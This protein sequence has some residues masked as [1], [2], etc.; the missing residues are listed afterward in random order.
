MSLPMPELERPTPGSYKGRHSPFYRG[1]WRGSAVTGIP[2]ASQL[3]LPLPACPLA[4]SPATGCLPVVLDRLAGRPTPISLALGPAPVADVAGR[5]VEHPVPARASITSS[6]S[7][8][9]PALI[10]TVTSAGAAT[11]PYVYPV[12]P[13]LLLDEAGEDWRSEGGLPPSTLPPQLGRVP[14]R[15]LASWPRASQTSHFLRV[16]GRPASAADVIPAGAPAPALAA[17]ITSAA[18]G[19]S[20]APP[21]SLVA[22]CHGF[23]GWATVD[24]RTSF[25]SGD[26]CRV[27]WRGGGRTAIRTTSWVHPY[28]HLIC[29]LSWGGHHLR[30]NQA[31]CLCPPHLLAACQWSWRP[32]LPSP[33]S[34]AAGGLPELPAGSIPTTVPAGLVAAPAPSGANTANN[35]A[36]SGLL[37]LA[38]CQWCRIDQLGD[39]L[40]QR[41]VLLSLTSWRGRTLPLSQLGRSLPKVKMLHR[42]LA[43]G[44]RPTV[45]RLTPASTPSP[46]V[47]STVA[48][49]IALAIPAGAAIACNNRKTDWL[50]AGGPGST[51]WAVDPRYG[52]EPPVTPTVAGDAAVP[53]PAGLFPSP[54]G[55]GYLRPRWLG[56]PLPLCH[57]LCHW[58]L[59][60]R[61]STR[62]AID[63]RDRWSPPGTAAAAGYSDLTTAAGPVAA[64]VAAG[65]T[66]AYIP[67]RR[68]AVLP[69]AYWLLAW[70]GVDVV[71]T[72]TTT[73]GA[74]PWCML[75]DRLVDRLVDLRVILEALTGGSFDV[76]IT[77]ENKNKEHLIK[78]VQ[79]E[80]EDYGVDEIT[81]MKGREDPDPDTDESNF[82]TKAH[83]VV[84]GEEQRHK[85]VCPEKQNNNPAR[86]QEGRRGGGGRVPS[87][88]GEF[89][90]RDLDDCLI[91]GPSRRRKRS[92]VRPGARSERKRGPRA[93]DEEEA[94]ASSPEDDDDDTLM[95]P[96][97]DK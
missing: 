64:P 57:L 15:L 59:A 95:G 19:P 13:S 23:T 62:W 34:G 37:P 35:M 24:P 93:K 87:E 38:A 77:N 65:V 48:G 29:P 79:E 86:C 78:V 91:G 68:L 49:M 82:I 2:A 30:A 51:S 80:E 25:P 47:T 92:K 20:A 73:G 63:S 9:R 16:A 26:S 27:L 88:R 81:Q 11:S 90:R 96:L 61:G 55:G 36:T 58:L 45:G 89:P 5:D 44:S 84:E 18:A 32:A 8:G 85:A 14:F 50:L 56:L 66:I 97:E 83:K 6:P 70:A 60:S 7:G 40:S 72:T 69:P 17:T 33:P 1:S 74:S 10:V 71:D 94:K 46:P 41:P 43:G 39:R 28:S 4:A 52:M 75:V 42:L 22:A 3:R 21:A 54:L 67:T 31:A 76:L 12:L 53:A